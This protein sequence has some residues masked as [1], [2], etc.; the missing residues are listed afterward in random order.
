MKVLWNFVYWGS[1]LHGSILNLFFKKYWTSGHFT[2]G[3]RI[4][5]ALKVILKLVNN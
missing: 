4:K 5:Q 1:L 3:G 2:I